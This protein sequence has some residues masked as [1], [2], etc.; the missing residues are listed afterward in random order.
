MQSHGILSIS[1]IFEC[2]V[3]FS[4]GTPIT[5]VCKYDAV[6]YRIVILEELKNV[7]R[8]GLERQSSHSDETSMNSLADT[9]SSTAPHV[10][11]ITPIAPSS[12][13][14]VAPTPIPIVVASSI[15]STSMVMVVMM[16]RT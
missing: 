11:V 7:L 14:V 15:A 9:T 13:M 3:P 6:F 2:D 5:P 8:R 10:V 16:I 4:S 12:T 1:S